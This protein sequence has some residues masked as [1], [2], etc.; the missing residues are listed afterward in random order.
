[1]GTTLD[2]QWGGLESLRMQGVQP[3]FSKCVNLKTLAWC[4]SIV[5][6]AYNGK[7]SGIEDDLDLPIACLHNLE[8]LRIH[9][10][11]LK[12][13]DFLDEMPKLRSL[14]LS[15]NF[16]RLPD[17]LGKMND[18][19]SLSIFGAVSLTTLPPSIADL[20]SLKELHIMA[21]GV[22]AVPD[23]LKPRKDMRIDIRRGA[24]R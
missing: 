19:E 5:S 12:N 4:H 14:S 8:N 13:L 2:E 20:P 21:S 18:L 1:M 22:K 15:C 17:S 10:G 24:L 7:V 16:S 3:D 11:T 6:Y 23:F 9:G